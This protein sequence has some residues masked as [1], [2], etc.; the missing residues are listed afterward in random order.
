MRANL[1]RFGAAFS[2]LLCCGPDIESSRC[3]GSVMIGGLSPVDCAPLQAECV[4][5]PF[6][7]ACVRRTAEEGCT[8]L[9]Q[10]GFSLQL[11]GVEKTE[12]EC[13]GELAL[14]EEEVDECDGACMA[15]VEDCDEEAFAACLRAP[16]GTL[17]ERIEAPPAPAPTRPTTSTG[18]GGGGGGGGG[19]GCCVT[20]RSGKPCGD[21][22]IARDRQCNVGPGCACSG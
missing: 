15:L 8:R 11:E 21:S 1:L 9:Y 7:V 17:P 10:C 20:C 6:V 14:L 22:C 19:G 3:E 18:C 2:F 12:A 4:D 5:T 13:A 16:C